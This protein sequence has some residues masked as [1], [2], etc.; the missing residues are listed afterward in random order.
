MDPLEHG[1]SCRQL[2]EPRPLPRPE[3]SGGF[4]FPSFQQEHA[5]GTRGNRPCEDEKQNY[6]EEVRG[7]R[8]KGETWARR[9]RI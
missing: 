9:S 8:A 4:Q 5:Q 3:V 1:L 7:A 2:D 6:E